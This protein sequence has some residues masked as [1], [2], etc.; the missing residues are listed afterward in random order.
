MPPLSF[1]DNLFK[2]STKYCCRAAKDGRGV[3]VVKFLAEQQVPR[4]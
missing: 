3:G 2:D 1:D 4:V